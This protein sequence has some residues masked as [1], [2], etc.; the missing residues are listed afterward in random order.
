MPNW[1]YFRLNVSGQQEDVDT[2]VENVKGSKEFD[3]E[4]R[5]FDFNHFIPQP[6]N[7]YRDNLSTDKEKELD[8]LGLPNWYTWNNA[9][10]GTKWNA[11]CDDF[12][13]VTVNGFPYEAIY[14]LRTAWAFPNP[15]IEKMIEMYPNLDFEI[16]GEEESSSYGVYIVSSEEI[17]NEEE[18]T[19]ID[20]MNGREVYYDRDN[21]W[22]AYMDDDTMVEDSDAFWP[23]NQYSWSE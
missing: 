6:E 22:W 14:D 16:E 7:L 18:P 4:G 3:T 15:V 10:W 9:N 21:D 11:V 1:F 17:W 5:E 8:S 2:F 23:I 12:D 19:L 20:E 13:E